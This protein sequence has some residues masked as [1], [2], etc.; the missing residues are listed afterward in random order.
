MLIH[1]NGFKEF[2]SKI[3]L[4]FVHTKSCVVMINHF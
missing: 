1:L 2:K 3:Q 4:A